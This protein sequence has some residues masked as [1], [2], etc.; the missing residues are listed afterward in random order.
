M[1]ITMLTEEPLPIGTQNGCFTVIAGFEAYQE[2]R[3]KVKIAKLE[4]EKQKF[5][6][7]ETSTWH[8]FTDVKS[9]DLHISQE[10]ETKLYKVQCK[11]GKCHFHSADFLFSK[12]WRDCGD[13]CGIKAK[14][15][16]ESA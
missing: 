2:E 5:I 4:E 8:N 7:G 6:N 1:S 15:Q 11:C 12:K 16:A 3:A 10:R 9:F 13:E 14:K